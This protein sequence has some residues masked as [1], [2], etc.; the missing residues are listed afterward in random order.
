MAPQ[1]IATLLVKLRS[2]IGEEYS[3]I[4]SLLQLL[5]S[6]CIILALCAAFA[7]KCCQE[8]FF[9]VWWRSQMLGVILAFGMTINIFGSDQYFSLGWYIAIMSMFHFSEFAITAVIRPQNLSTES[10]LLNH[11][12][13]YFLAA[14]T[15]WIEYV[16]EMWLFPGW[17]SIY[18]LSSIGLILCIG[19]EA[20][21][22]IAMLTAFNN[23]D[24][25]IRTRREDQHELVTS[26]I[27]SLCRHPSYV[28]WF[29]W[30]IGTQ[31]VLCN[32]LCTI[33]YAYVSWRFFYERV[34]EEEMTLLH[35]FGQQYALY[36]SK[37][38]T[39]L[40]FIEGYLIS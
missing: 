37:V 1:A 19:G 11:S 21:R 27:Y 39:G 29:Y 17:K 13:A 2:L 40:P 4:H 30:S 26:G 38:P 25:L 9:Q 35:F 10:F 31:I 32:P 8:T 6:A 22:K 18:W 33:A 16:I 12:K 3:E 14:L 34:W 20:A 24:H 15:S 28:G 36:Q 23:F 5:L 7:W